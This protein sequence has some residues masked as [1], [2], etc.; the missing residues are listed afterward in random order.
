MQIE[1]AG[2]TSLLALLGS[3]AL[4]PWLVLPVLVG[5]FVDHI[6]LSESEAG[7]AVA[8]GALGSA[9]ATIPIS[10]AIH[11]LDLRRL[12]LSGLIIMAIADGLSMAA[13][14]LPVWFFLL[15][16][17]LYGVGA[18]CVFSSVM[19][20][21]AG[22]KE[23]DRAYGLF[24]AIQFALSAVGLYG[25]PLVLPTLGIGGMY[26]G[27]VVLDLIAMAIIPRLPGRD[28]RRGAGS[29]APLEWRVVLRRTSLVCL[30]G[31]G[32]FEAANMSHFAYAERIGVSFALEGGDI[33]TILGIATIVGIP[34][35]FT[36]VLLGDRFGHFAPI[37][38]ALCC[39]I[40][41]LVLLM[42]G[43][44][45]LAY[46]SAMCMLSIGWA[47][48]LPYFQAVEAEL[49]P[50]GSV[51]VAGGFATALGASVGPA[52]A[53]MLVLPGQYA[54]IYIAAITTYLL[55]VVLMRFVTTRV[56]AP[57]NL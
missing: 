32:L 41:A 10:L 17:F 42:A 7:W 15:L 48:A 45:P 56:Q 52:M 38:V 19:S 1:Q 54:G 24:M 55:V 8:I 50:G 53:A 26:A 16:R 4:F 33:G 40:L 9:L 49:D 28:E 20:A 11:H 47:F 35:A 23:P 25:L 51:V 22:W 30:L 6:G 12:A 37:A 3:V 2:R 31:I 57:A 34:A 44:E 13:A 36:V 21:Y 43:Q 39:Q 18:A 27:V 29:Q 5:G 46:I 14:S